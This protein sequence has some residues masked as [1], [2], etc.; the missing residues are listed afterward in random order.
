VKDLLRRLYSGENDVDFLGARRTVAI[1]TAVLVV[2]LGGSLLFRG[3]NLGIEFEG[4]VVWE[5]PQGE[6]VSTGDVESLL[7]GLGV[8]RDR[9]QTVS[10]LS[11]DLFR[12]RGSTDDLERQTEVQEALAELNGVG[13]DDVS[14]EE[15]GPS[16]GDEITRQARTA[17]IWFLVV[18]SAY[19]AIRFEWRMAVAALVALVHDIG[20][21]VGI[22]S[23]FQ[24][25]VTP[26][27]VIA[28]LTILGYSLYDT[29]VV[30]DKVNDNTALMRARGGESYAEVVNRSLNQVVMRSINTTITSLL[31]VLS[32][33]F[34]G[35][36][37]L[38][39]TA[40]QEFALALAVGIAAGSYSSIFIAA[41]V[42]VALRSAKPPEIREASEESVDVDHPL[43]RGGAPRP[44]RRS[45][46][47]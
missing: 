35:S 4:G 25:E 46:K 10:S 22:Y 47:R 16:W 30:F 37:L 29:I 8:T 14:R 15:V 24:F 12:V 39:A 1:V 27:T 13:V 11:G 40:L 20:M 44:R 36:V 9:V 23:L 26:A 32:M 7:A 2:V 43:A 5:V 34:V 33:L 6:G 17:L 42:L 21:S 28:F 19:V 31:P 18:I 41:P 38:G 45:K 3:L